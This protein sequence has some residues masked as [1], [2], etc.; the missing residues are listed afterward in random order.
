MVV[1]AAGIRRLE[2]RA[3]DRICAD[4]DE[5]VNIDLRGAFLTAQFALPHM[6]RGSAIVHISSVFGIRAQS[7]DPGFHAAKGG[8]IQLTRQMAIAVANDGLRV[9]CVSPGVIDTPLTHRWL[10]EG[11]TMKEVSKWHPMGR[12]GY[13]EEVAAA[14]LFLASD[15]ASFITGVNLPVDGGYLAAGVG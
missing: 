7:S 4:W 11:S 3:Q 9:N 5:V 6:R 15:E 14:V 1:T 8:L 13:P 2:G 12:V 10:N